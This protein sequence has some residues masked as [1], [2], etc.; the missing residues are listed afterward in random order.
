MGEHSC[1]K[2]HHRRNIYMGNVYVCSMGLQSLATVESSGA[3][4][5]LLAPRARD[6]DRPPPSTSI[7]EAVAYTAR[8][9]LAC[10]SAILPIAIFSLCRILSSLDMSAIVCKTVSLPLSPTP[11]STGRMEG[12]GGCQRVN[13]CSKET[14]RIT[15]ISHLRH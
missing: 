12:V 7:P 4:P 14:Q 3:V 10:A 15:S 8:S 13:P 2:R 9:C 5:S 6:A 11:A 1:L